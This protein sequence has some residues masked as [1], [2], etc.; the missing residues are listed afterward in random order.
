VTVGNKRKGL[1]GYIKISK[2]W[3]IVTVTF[4]AMPPA[5]IKERSAVLQPFWPVVQ[6]RASISGV[7]TADER[8]KKAAMLR[9]VEDL[10][11]KVGVLLFRIGRWINEE[12]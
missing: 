1:P 8:A 6:P 3:P 10:M 5:A 7:G 2:G 11:L 4:R 12:Y 9:M